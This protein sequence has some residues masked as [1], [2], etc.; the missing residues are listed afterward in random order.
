MYWS[1]LYEC[2]SYCD[3]VAHNVA[4][5]FDY[6]MKIMFSFNHSIRSILISTPISIPI[7]Y[8]IIQSENIVNINNF[9][10]I[11]YSKLYIDEATKYLVFSIKHN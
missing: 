4:Y 5:H 11:C 10:I 6:I 7:T 1:T 2:G 8:Y 3:N 9:E